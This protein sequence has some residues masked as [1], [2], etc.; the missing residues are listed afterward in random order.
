MTATLPSERTTAWELAQRERIRAFRAG[1]HVLIAAEG[2]LPTPGWDVDLRQS[3]Q[4]VFPPQ[5]DLLRRERPGVWPDVLQPYR[6]AEVVRYPADSPTV[7]VHHR[8]GVDVVEIEAAGED[9]ADFTAAVAD[10]HDER[11]GPAGGEATGMSRNLSF[12]EA[13]ADAL[14][15]LPRPFPPHPD[16]LTSV[17][18]VEIGGLFGG[19]AGFHH[20]FV[21][22][23][24]SSD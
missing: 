1:R 20:L 12:D 10:R 16:S 9:L 13:F 22:V 21:R 17:T 23:R 2:N 19:V 3:P 11:S 14:S 4:D 24:G 7:T 6:H 5:Y 18:V 15:N 8:D